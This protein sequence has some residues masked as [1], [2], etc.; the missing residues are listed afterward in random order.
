MLLGTRPRPK[1]RGNR[2]VTSHQQLSTIAQQPQECATP[3]KLDER[4]DDEMEMVDVIGI[5]QSGLS[6]SNSSGSDRQTA[7]YD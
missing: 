4:T 2:G 7:S 5:N 6:E 3:V 1:L